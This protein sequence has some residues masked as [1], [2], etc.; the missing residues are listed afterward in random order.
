[1][2]GLSPN[3]TA[4]TLLTGFAKSNIQMQGNAIK[5][6]HEGNLAK[7]QSVTIELLEPGMSRVMGS[8][9]DVNFV[10]GMNQMPVEESFGEMLSELGSK[11]PTSS[12]QNNEI[13][14]DNDCYSMGKE[15]QGKPNPIASTATKAVNRKKEKERQ[16]E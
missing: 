1:M 5:P 11:N 8:I 16:G 13:D 3:S 4:I 12:E 9:P 7:L 2:Q 15:K 10:D 6:L 14:F